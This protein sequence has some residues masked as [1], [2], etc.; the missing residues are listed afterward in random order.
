MRKLLGM[1]LSLVA[2]SC[3][4]ALADAPRIADGE[5]FDY[6]LYVKQGFITVKAG[7]A[8]LSVKEKDGAYEASLELKALSFVDMIYHLY[9]RMST[10]LTPELKPL[11]YE[12]HA[13]EGRSVYDEVS[14]FSYPQEG[15]CGISSRRTFSDGKVDVGETRREGSVFDLLSLIFHARRLDVAGLKPGMRI[16]VSV[17]SGVKVRD[18]SLV[19]KGV[20]EIKAHDG[21]KIKAGV[22]D[23]RSEESGGISAQFVFSQDGSR[24]PQ[25]IDISQKLGSLSARLCPAK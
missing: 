24:I 20:E 25:R 22:F 5:E 15:G 17:I 12:K 11:R 23:L 19:Y 13:E 16:D 6:A 3:W 7:T 2:S 18:Q 10:R 4:T 8:H 1:A 21:R 9:V 14:V